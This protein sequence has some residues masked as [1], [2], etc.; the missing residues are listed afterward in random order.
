[1][2]GN[3]DNEMMKAGKRKRGKAIRE[4]LGMIGLKET[5]TNLITV[6]NG[7]GILSK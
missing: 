4:C 1:M 6:D 3:A 2:K 5:Q 7:R